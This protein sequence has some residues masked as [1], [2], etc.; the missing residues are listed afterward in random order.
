MLRKTK[1]ELILQIFESEGFTE[2]TQEAI[3]LINSKLVEIYGSGGMTSS[4]YI[5]E[6]LLAESKK[7][8]FEDQIYINNEV[9]SLSDELV[10]SLNFD[11]LVNAEKSLLKLNNLFA[12]FQ[13]SGDKEAIFRCQDFAKRAKIRAQLIADNE[14]LPIEKREVKREIA[15]WFEIWL[16]TPDIFKD[17]LALRT[18]SKDFQNKFGIKLNE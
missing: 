7:I 11:T 6:I 9:S 14:K 8:H 4:A 12:N 17:W 2:L 5:A 15:F 10:Q 18:S 13:H 3:T 16:N 1:K